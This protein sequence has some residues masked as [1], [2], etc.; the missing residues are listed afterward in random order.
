MIT[1][2]ATVLYQHLKLEATVESFRADKVWTAPR[3]SKM[4][5]LDRLIGEEILNMNEVQAEN[6][7]VEICRVLYLT[8]K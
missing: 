1:A 5:I 4:T 8:I 6:I 3:A 7:Q 2:P